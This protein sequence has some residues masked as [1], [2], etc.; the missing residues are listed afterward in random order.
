MMNHGSNGRNELA[1]R[2]QGP[3]ASMLLVLTLCIPGLANAR[4]ILVDGS[5][6]DWDPTGWEMDAPALHA[7]TPGVPTVNVGHVARD[8]QDQGEYIW[9]DRPNDERKDFGTD[10][11]VDLIEFRVTGDQNNLY[12]MA[13]MRD[14]DQTTGN[15]AP[16]VQ[17]AIDTNQT[18]LVGNSY[19]WGHW[20]S[21]MGVDANTQVDDA[22]RW[23]WLVTTMFG[24]G[25][26]NLRV[27]NS[28]YA[29]SILG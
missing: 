23:E 22:A 25:S 7:P 17:I 6:T 1:R 27:F 20:Q 11:R 2:I 13:Q 28:A 10:S 19:F 8:L 5:A 16:M 18:S 14:I 29:A 26:N 3:L 12:F 21:G 4:T 15:G 24:S 9:S